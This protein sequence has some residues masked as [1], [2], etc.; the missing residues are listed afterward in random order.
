MTTATAIDNLTQSLESVTSDDL[1]ERLVDLN[2]Q[3][4]AI[5]VLLKA[6]MARERAT[7][8]GRTTTAAKVAPLGVQ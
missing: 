5:R 4:D 6:R 2:A 1:Q 3:A 8:R 7:R